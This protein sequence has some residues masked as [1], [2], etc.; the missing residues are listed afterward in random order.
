MQDLISQCSDFFDQF[1]VQWATRLK[2][3]MSANSS[4]YL[5]DIGDLLD[6]LKIERLSGTVYPSMDQ[7]FRAFNI[8]A[9]VDPDRIKVVILGQDP[10]H[11]GQ[12]TGLAF[13]VSDENDLD[14]S[15]PPSLSNIYKTLGDDVGDHHTLGRHHTRQGVL[16]LNTALS[17]RE[18]QPFSHAKP[19]RFVSLA[20][21][22]VL[23]ESKTPKVFL[24]W[25][26]KSSDIY[27]EAIARYK[28][29]GKSIHKVLKTSHPSPFSYHKGFKNCKHFSKTNE[30][31][32]AMYKN[33][34]KPTID[35]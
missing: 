18:S 4:D 31:L 17:V 35:W 20:A 12:A 21:I 10:Y 23:H 32:A 24:L 26:D 8:D 11:G 5:Q 9:C 19:W 1:P 7:T 14:L 6:Y 25:G 34:A 15:L 16:L 22:Q 28:T 3:R 27:N 30:F 2:N 13:S 29:P 33:H